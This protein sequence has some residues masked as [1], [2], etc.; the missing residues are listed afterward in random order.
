MIRGTTAGLFATL[1]LT[2]AVAGDGP[3]WLTDYGQARELARATGKPILL[4]FRCER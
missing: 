1:L 3:K 4:V 2:T